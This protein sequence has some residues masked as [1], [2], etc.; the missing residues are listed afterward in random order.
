[1]AEVRSVRVGGTDG[2]AFE[3]AAAQFRATAVHLFKG[4][5]IKYPEYKS[6]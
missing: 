3:R 6:T 1:M 2:V 5:E 4:K